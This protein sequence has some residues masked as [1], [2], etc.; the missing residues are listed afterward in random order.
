VHLAGHDLA[1][2]RFAG[3]TSQVTRVFRVV[4]QLCV[5]LYKYVPDVVWM[6]EGFKGN[7]VPIQSQS[8]G[9]T[10]WSF[11]IIWL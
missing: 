1:G 10:C 8:L 6:L 5:L 3:P 4:R 11:T 9:N 7:T 2:P